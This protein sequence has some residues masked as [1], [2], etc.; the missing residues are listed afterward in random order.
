MGVTQ[1]MIDYDEDGTKPD[2]LKMRKFNDIVE[3]N[4]KLKKRVTKNV[5]LKY[6]FKPEE[7][8]WL[9]KHH[10][11]TI[12][13]QEDKIQAEANNEEIKR[14]TKQL[15]LLQ[16]QKQ[17]NDVELVSWKGKDCLSIKED[18]TEWRVV[19][20]RQQKQSGK[21]NKIVHFIKKK[22]VDDMR[23][24]I[25]LL[26]SETNE[27]GYREVVNVLMQKHKLKFDINA[28]NGGKNRSKH[29]FPL[30]YYPVKIL[31]HLHEIKYSGGGKITLKE[32]GAQ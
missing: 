8:V 12:K 17:S 25:N 22:H 32:R 2:F 6:G 20:A 11:E 9:F 29:Y 13:M 24:I 26:T 27:T 28:F 4:H 23:Q 21:I 3:Y 1:K 10:G 31:E 14:L 30:Y 18:N 5:L 15:E 19:E 16:S 7:V